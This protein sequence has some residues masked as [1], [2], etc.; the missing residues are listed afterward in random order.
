MHGDYVNSG[1]KIPKPPKKNLLH[2]F[3]SHKVKK[4]ANNIMEY[5]NSLLLTKPFNTSPHL[6]KFFSVA[7]EGGAKRFTQFEYAAKE[8]DLLE[9]E[10]SPKEEKRKSER[11]RSPHNV[12]GSLSPHHTVESYIHINSSN[13]EYK[14]EKVKKSFSVNNV[15]GHYVKEYDKS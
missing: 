10:I 3:T 7:S 11:V 14:A 8:Y 4:S 5:L 12:T 9:S 15:L 13:G 1:V 6:E 2:N